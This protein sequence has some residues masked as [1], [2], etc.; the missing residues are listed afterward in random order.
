MTV[1]SISRDFSPTPGGRFRRH[2]PFSG[3]DFR[4]RLL[5]PALKRVS[6]TGGQVIVEFDGLVGAPSSF[7]EEAFGGL[8]RLHPEYD[9]TRLLLRA[10]DHSLDTYIAMVDRFMREA[11]RRR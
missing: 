7:F 4:E 1:I 5:E 10:R 11:L 3:E 6:E 8:A 2:G 9:Y